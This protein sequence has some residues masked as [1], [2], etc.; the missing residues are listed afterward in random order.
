MRVRVSDQ[1]LEDC[2]AKQAQARKCLFRGVVGDREE[3]SET[4]AI[5]NVSYILSGT[6]I[7]FVLV[8]DWQ[9]ECLTAVNDVH[10]SHPISVLSHAVKPLNN[11]NGIGYAHD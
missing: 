5:T 7:T 2:P 6:K 8:S 1:I 11:Q 10:P 3:P 9:V 4:H